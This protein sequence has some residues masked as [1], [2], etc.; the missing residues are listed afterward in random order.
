LEEVYL[1]AR[2]DRSAKQ[3]DP[4]A[5]MVQADDRFDPR[6]ASGKRGQCRTLALTFAL[7]ATDE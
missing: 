3:A 7:A 4:S 1:L 6:L 5:R 2:K